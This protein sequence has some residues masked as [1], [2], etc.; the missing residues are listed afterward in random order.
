MLPLRNLQKVYIKGL[1]S[2]S[3]D[4]KAEKHLTLVP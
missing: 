3:L 1:K 4:L 2:F